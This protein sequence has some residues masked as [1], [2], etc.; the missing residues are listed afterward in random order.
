MATLDMAY[1]RIIFGWGAGSFRY[2]FPVYQSNYKEIW[3]SKKHSKRGWEGRK[4]YNYAHND[5][6]QF[7][8][9]YGIVGCALIAALFLLL[10]AYLYPLIMVD[11]KAY[12]YLFTEY[13]NFHLQ[14]R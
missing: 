11:G 10:M 6:V 2:I 13:P 7:L 9:E 4:I 3:Y 14:F 1:D 5:W 8:A 12:A